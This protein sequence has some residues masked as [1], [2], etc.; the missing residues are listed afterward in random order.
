MGI[1]VIL[2]LV[3]SPA[4]AVS[5]ADIIASWTAPEPA[6]TYDNTIP[7]CGDCGPKP[8]LY[9]SVEDAKEQQRHYHDGYP[10]YTGD[11]FI[12]LSPDH[13]DTRDDPVTC[14]SCENWTPLP[15]AEP[16][17]MPSP[18]PTP[19]THSGFT[20]PSLNWPYPDFLKPFSKPSIP[21]S[22]IV[23]PSLIPE[24]KSCPPAVPSRPL[25]HVMVYCSCSPEATCDCVDPE[26]G[27]HYP[28]GSDMEGNQYIVK[29]GCQCTWG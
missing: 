20:K 19:S 6:A 23:K 22:P 21:S 1:V 25:Y 10:A 29:P 18:T 16:Y 4:L 3:S 15:G 28:I 8:T 5:K 13:D 2:A 9:P 24:M 7:S 27:E 26:T 12:I 17:F 11:Y 14:A